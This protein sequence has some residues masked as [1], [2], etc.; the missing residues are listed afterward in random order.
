MR[1]LA[2][3]CS[4]LLAAQETPPGPPHGDLDALARRVDAA[5]HPDGPKAPIT[6]F[7]ANLELH[8]LGDPN[9]A[10]QVDLSVQFLEWERS[11]GHKRPLIRYR[12]HEASA[13]ERGRDEH[14]YWQLVQGQ[15]QDLTSPGL[16][17]DLKAG[18]RDTNLARQLLRC[19]DPAA[20][21]RSLQAPSPVA[22]ETLRVTRSTTIACDV[23]EGGLDAFP[24]LQRGGEDSPVIA[25]I[26]VGKDSGTLQALRLWPLAD[27]KKDLARG[28]LIVLADLGLQDGLL[29]PRE[30]RHYFAKPDGGLEQQSKTILIAVSLRPDLRVADFDRKKR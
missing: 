8:V 25:R 16:E 6:A 15:P 13:I 17:T 4:T 5:H 21:L 30:L 22:D 12:V 2:A 28:E 19:L 24:L 3:L 9:H 1:F 26:Y 11:N 14:G 23:V 10:G 18:Q 7:R 27:G 29:V 20:V